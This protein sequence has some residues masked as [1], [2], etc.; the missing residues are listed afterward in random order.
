MDSSEERIQG[1][2]RGVSPGPPASVVDSDNSL[3]ESAADFVTGGRKAFG[4]SLAAEEDVIEEASVPH[5]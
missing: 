5:L 2:L 3:D 1:L 4:V